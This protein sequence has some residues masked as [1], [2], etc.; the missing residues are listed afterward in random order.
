MKNVFL[1]IPVRIFGEGSLSNGELFLFA[2]VGFGLIKL[3]KYMEEK[4]ENSFLSTFGE[5]FI[6]KLGYAFLLSAILT[7]VFRVLG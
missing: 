3:G 1:R 5:V 2:L 7:G 4:I 6:I